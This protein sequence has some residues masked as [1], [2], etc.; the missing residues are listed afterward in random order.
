V[1]K[2]TEILEENVLKKLYGYG[3]TPP[4][5][6]ELSVELGKS[7]N[8]IRDILEKLTYNNKATRVKGD[9]YFHKE[10]MERIKEG[11]VSHLKEKKEMMPTDFRSLFEVSRKY[12]IPIL[13]HLD[14]IKLTIRVGDKRVLRS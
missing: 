5:P 1:D 11:V 3:L 13:E 2:D 14:E 10:I 12:M 6:K 7:E 8:Q 9:L 4:T